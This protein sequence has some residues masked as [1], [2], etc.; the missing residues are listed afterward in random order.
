MGYLVALSSEV[1]RPVHGANHSLP[2]GAKTESIRSYISS[3]LYT[4]M[5]WFLITHR[6]ISSIHTLYWPNY[7]SSFCGSRRR[8]ATRTCRSVSLIW[9]SVYMFILGTAVLSATV[10][11]SSECHSDLQCWVPQW[12]AVVSATVTSSAECHSDLQCWV[13]QWPAVLS[14]TVIGYRLTVY[15]SGALD[16]VFK[17]RTTQLP[18]VWRTVYSVI[19]IL[20]LLQ[21]AWATWESGWRATI[22]PQA[23]GCYHWFKA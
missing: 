6:A 13:P 11:C 16:F 5:A 4:F 1:R 14:A 8:S 21:A 23:T 12:P 10:T 2:S 7:P 9:W 20:S 3:R 22:G 19:L 17:P 15:T 18:V